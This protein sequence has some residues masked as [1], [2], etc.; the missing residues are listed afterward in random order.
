PLSEPLLEL[1]I[2]LVKIKKSLE[3]PLKI[4][5]REFVVPVDLTIGYSLHGESGEEIKGKDF[6]LDP[7]VLTHTLKERI[8]ELNAKNLR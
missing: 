6:S 4:R 2:M 7:V 1:A 5:D 8:D 3:I